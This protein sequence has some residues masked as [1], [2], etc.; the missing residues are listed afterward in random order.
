MLFS[1][2]LLHINFTYLLLAC[3]IVE[4]SVVRARILKPF[5]VDSKIH[6]EVPLYQEQRLFIWKVTGV[7]KLLTEREDKTFWRLV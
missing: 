5:I 3:A 1:L 6:N 4:T 7:L 2:Y